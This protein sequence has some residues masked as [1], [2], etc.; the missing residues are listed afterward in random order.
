MPP[1]RPSLGKK[2]QSKARKLK[3]L[4]NSKNEDKIILGLSVLILVT[5]SFLNVCYGK[6]MELGMFVVVFMLSYQYSKDIVISLALGMILSILLSKLLPDN[7]LFSESVEGFADVE[8]G[9]KEI[10]GGGN[11][12]TIVKKAEEKKQEASSTSTNTTTQQKTEEGGGGVLGFEDDDDN[13]INENYIDIGTSFL[14]AYKTLKPQQI[15]AMTNDTKELL[16]TQKSLVSAMESLTP[17][18]TEGKKMLET[19][20][21]FFPG[22][23]ITQL[24]G[25]VKK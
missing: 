16:A 12:E 6:W 22:Q 23:D 17:V 20:K 10:E 21:G 24:Q 2:L 3:L 9:P 14:E 13:D 15:E 18:V 4:P 8:Q 7:R 19:F 5:Y 25:L 1:K 11:L